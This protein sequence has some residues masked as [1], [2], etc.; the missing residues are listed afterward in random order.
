MPVFADTAYHDLWIPNPRAALPACIQGLEF[1]GQLLGP[2][3]FSGVAVSCVLTMHYL[4][5]TSCSTVSKHSHMQMPQHI[6]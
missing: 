3:N 4:Q 2:L 1:F 5:I 6:Q